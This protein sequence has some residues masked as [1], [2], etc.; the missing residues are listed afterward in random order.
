MVVGRIL[1]APAWPLGV[2]VFPLA[3]KFKSMRV[4]CV[5]LA[6]N[7][8]AARFARKLSV[9]SCLVA[10]STARGDGLSGIE[11][12]SSPIKVFHRRAIEYSSACGWVV[13]WRSN[14]Q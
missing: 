13:F 4:R 8:I 7:R 14:S 2:R 9:E 5:L 3:G 6:V 1:L 12:Q 11:P 10:M